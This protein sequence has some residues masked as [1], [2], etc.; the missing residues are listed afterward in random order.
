MTK[1]QGPRSELDLS[2][3]EGRV[4]A[5]DIVGNEVIYGR[6]CIGTRSSSRCISLESSWGRPLCSGMYHVRMSILPDFMLFL[7]PRRFQDALGLNARSTHF[8]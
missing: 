8:S 7:S 3:G 2:S 5:S 6:N 1:K 4:K